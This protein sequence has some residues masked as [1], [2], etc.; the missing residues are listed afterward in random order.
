MVS[1]NSDKYFNKELS[2]LAFNER[3]LQEAQNSYNPLIERMRFLS[4]SANNLDEFYMVRVAGLKSQITHGAKD[5]NYDSFEIIEELL[6]IHQRSNRLMNAQ[7]ESWKKF[8]DEMRLRNIDIL[9]PKHYLSYDLKWLKQ[10][11]KHYVAPYLSI[12][13]VQKSEPFP[14]IPNLGVAACVFLEEDD[15]KKRVIVNISS[16]LQRFIQ[17]PALRETKPEKQKIRFVTLEDIL[18]LFVKDLFPSA[19]VSDYGILHVIRDSEL[20]LSDEADDLISSFERALSKRKEGDIVRVTFSS[21]ISSEMEQ[22]L[23]DRLKIDEKTIACSSAFLSINYLSELCEKDCLDDPNLKYRKQNIRF[24]ERINDYGGD[25]FAAIDAKDIIIH[26]PYESFDVVVKFLQQAANDPYVT[27][28]KQTLYRI[29]KNNSIVLALID[30]AKAGKNVTVVVELKARFDEAYNLNW[31]K[32]LQEAGAKVIY[33]I[34]KLKIHAKMSLVHRRIPGEDG[35]LKKHSYVHYGTGNY[36]PQNAQ[37][38][39]DL[40]FFT[41]D[42]FLCSDAEKVFN[43]LETNTKPENLKKLAMAPFNLRQ[44]IE[45]LINTEIKN[46]KNGKPA[47]IWLKMNSLADEKLIDRLYEASCAGVNIKIIVRGICCLKPGIAGLSENIQVKSIVGRFLEHSRIYCFGNGNNLPSPNA[48]VFIGPVDWIDHKID[49]RVEIMVPIENPTVHEQVLGQIMQANINDRKQSWDLQSNGEYV[50]LPF[51]KSAFSAHEFF[52]SNPSL[53]GRGSALRKKPVT[54]SYISTTQPN[55][56]STG[57]EVAVIDIGSNSIRLVIYDGLKRTPLALFNEKVSCKLAKGLEKSNLLNPKGVM[58]AYKSIERFV[59]IVRSMKIKDLICF[60]TSAVRDA[61]DGMDFVYNVETNCNIK[62]Q[63]LSGKEEALLSGLAI[64][65]AFYAVDGVVGDI[66][67]GSLELSKVGFDPDNRAKHAKHN[68]VSN[69]F[70]FPIGSLRMQEYCRKTPEKAV[71]IIESHLKEFPFNTTLKGK[72][73]CAVGGGFR[74]I[75]KIHIS[76]TRHPVKVIEQLYVTPSDLMKTID[77]ILGSSYRELEDLPTLSPGRVDTLVPSTLVLKSIIEIGEPDIISFSTHG[78]REGILFN[79]LEPF[80]QGDDPLIA[81]CSDMIDHL[82][83]DSSITAANEKQWVEFGESLHK[84]ISPIFKNIPKDTNI[85]NV[86][87]LRKAACILGCL[88]WHEH[89]A[90][91]ADMAFRW[92]IDSKI[93]GMNHIER[94]F[95]ASALFHRY[96]DKDDP[97]TTRKPQNLL[98]QSQIKHAKIVGQAMHLGYHLSGGSRNI[99]T[100]VKLYIKG[101]ELI[102]SCKKDDQSLVNSEVYKRLEKLAKTMGLK[103]HPS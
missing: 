55:Y 13:H 18:K 40:S 97:S 41:G 64:A 6:K 56:Y 39:S 61:V 96:R 102:L 3:V 44:S 66:G 31:G 48:K 69:R 2:W 9:S 52:V 35:A 30:A 25:C 93:P 42:P 17:L 62:I 60:A 24:P 16:K 86:E 47:H 54:S 34:P 45:K 101:E 90:Y 14:L 80:I 70:S 76:R 59:K 32:E 33:G 21:S 8:I 85:S 49:R 37:I 83:P 68:I 58:L 82:S 50:R 73:F 7:Q 46:A 12:E 79:K 1:T 63:I 78:I 67:G 77:L 19:T 57:K 4:I 91:R 10:Y 43:F 23:S 81:G 20:V 75:A 94:V 27:E 74:A 5:P 53:S 28:I 84:W 22:F 29:G 89:S 92:V 11:F 103:I 51:N 99:L 87:R 88:A 98:R 65:S 38:Y 26:H 72:T 15:I 36:H 95:I 71:N 100:R